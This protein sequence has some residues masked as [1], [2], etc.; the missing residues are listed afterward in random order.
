MRKDINSSV[1][2]KENRNKK[3]ID[4]NSKKKGKRNKKTFNTIFKFLHDNLLYELD[5]LALIIYWAFFGLGISETIAFLDFGVEY[6]LIFITYALPLTVTVISIILT[7]LKRKI[8]GLTIKEFNIIRSKRTYRFDH[9]LYISIVILFLATISCTFDNSVSLIA[10]TLITLI[11]TFVVIHQEMIILLEEEAKIKNIILE[12]LKE[13]IADENQGTKSFKS[14]LIEKALLQVLLHYGYIQTLN[15]CDYDKNKNDFVDKTLITFN[16][17]LTRR[18]YTTIEDFN[19]EKNNPCYFEFKESLSESIKILYLDF[20]KVFEKDGEKY[21]SFLFS[22]EKLE[23]FV[24]LLIMLRKIEKTY[25]LKSVGTFTDF[26]FLVYDFNN[27]FLNDDRSGDE[28]LFKTNIHNTCR[29]FYVYATIE[30]LQHETLDFFKVEFNYLKSNYS[31]AQ[32]VTPVLFL[33]SCLLRYLL[34]AKG[35]AEFKR[36]ISNFLVY[37][38]SFGCE[39]VMIGVRNFIDNSGILRALDSLLKIKDIVQ[40]NEG[41]FS[42]ISTISDENDDKYFSDKH[43]ILLFLEVNCLCSKSC[44]KNEEVSKTENSFKECFKEI[45][46]FDFNELL[47]IFEEFNKL[48]SDALGIDNSFNNNVIHQKLENLRKLYNRLMLSE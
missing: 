32:D 12:A 47:K 41:L 27:A 16:R 10:L 5:I 19:T 15:D 24:F 46:R 40:D 18:I 43:F 8:F 44:Y 13:E 29:Y 23:F 39:G 45:K 6:I 28:N 26:E 30:S 21:R 2:K 37:N 48:K 33:Y 7:L 31:K 36:E 3:K 14:K 20:R 1:S 25:E 9:I 17:V 22:D 34:Y 42:L 38:K 35:N 4:C 11:F